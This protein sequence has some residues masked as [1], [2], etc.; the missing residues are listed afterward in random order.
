MNRNKKAKRPAR[1]LETTDTF[2]LALRSSSKEMPIQ[3]KI[4]ILIKRVV[5][6]SVL[7]NKKYIKLMKER[8]NKSGEASIQ[9]S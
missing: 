4:I 2:S 9:A 6:F 8:R 3:R 5:L 1:S 7:L